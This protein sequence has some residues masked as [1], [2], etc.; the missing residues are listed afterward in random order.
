MADTD[1]IRGFSPVRLRGAGAEVAGCVGGSGP[2]LL[3][4]HGYPQTRLAWREVAP[5]LARSFTVVLF[6]LRGYG[7]SGMP[8]IDQQA[9]AYS[10]RAMA[11]DLKAGM[12]H[13]GFPRFG[14][15]GHDRGARAAYRLALDHPDCV[16]RLAVLS[17]LPTCSMWRKLQDSEYAMTAFRWFFLAQ[18]SAVV[19]DLLCGAARQYLHATLAGWTK[20]KDLRTFPP[21]VLQAYENAFCRREAIAASCADY[22]AGWTIDRLDDLADLDR[23]RAVHCPVLAIW[24]ATEFPDSAEMLDA[25]RE[26]APNLRGHALDCGHF[27]AEEAPQETARLLL[28][29]FTSSSTPT[30]PHSELPA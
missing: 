21:Q 3:L 18:P 22:R 24:G 14:I 28:E 27:V 13:L 26:L 7:D 8:S 20:S 30:E 10:K 11:A 23:G 16:E 4:V 6:D 17:I 29:F 5:V 19:E 15:V 9:S 1:F 2:P 25:W 12:E